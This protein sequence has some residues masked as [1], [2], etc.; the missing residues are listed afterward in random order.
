MLADHDT[1]L[2]V[3]DYFLN[4]D[5]FG[6]VHLDGDHYIR[7]LDVGRDRLT[8]DPRFQ[9]DFNTVIPGVELRPHG[10]GVSGMA[11]SGSD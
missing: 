7:V 6:K 2:I 1:R 9:I 8:A 4:E 11:M 5:N 3:S 10:V